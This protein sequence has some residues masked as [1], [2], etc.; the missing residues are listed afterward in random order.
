VAIAWGHATLSSVPQA[1]AVEQE[2][3]P[4]IFCLR[5]LIRLDIGD[6]TAD[7]S[8]QLTFMVSAVSR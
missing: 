7:G 5:R 4:T 8:N 6:D 2:R 3:T 1:Q